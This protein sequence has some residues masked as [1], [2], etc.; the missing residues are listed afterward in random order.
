MRSFALF[1]IMKIIKRDHRVKDNGK[2]IIILNGTEMSEIDTMKNID[3]ALR[4]IVHSMEKNYC[5]MASLIL[6]LDQNIGAILDQNRAKIEDIRRINASLAAEAWADYLEKEYMDRIESKWRDLHGVAPTNDSD[7]TEVFIQKFI[8]GLH[9]EV[10]RYPSDT[11]ENRMKSLEA[12]H[13]LVESE[14][15]KYHNNKK[16]LLALLRLPSSCVTIKRIGNSFEKLGFKQPSTTDPTA[17][18]IDL[19]L[20]TLETALLVESGLKS[21]IVEKWTNRGLSIPSDFDAA[22]P[23]AE[24]IIR[25]FKEVSAEN[26]AMADELELFP[27]DTPEKRQT[28]LTIILGLVNDEENF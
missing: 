6:T 22:L 20:K 21:D 14:T 5:I 12:I 18:R 19:M 7:T 9:L 10:G 26:F 4:D 23:T 15:K 13:D 1:E 24:F 25:F 3:S 27:C 2:N 28:S 16:T 11:P 8:S 17:A